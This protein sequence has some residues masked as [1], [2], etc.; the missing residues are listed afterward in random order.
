MKYN[1]VEIQQCNMCHSSLDMHRLLGLRMKGHQGFF[2]PRN[3]RGVNIYQCR[4]CGLIFCNPLPLPN[5]LQDHYGLPPDDYWEESWLAHDPAHFAGQIKVL[6]R[7]L[8]NAYGSK[9]LDVGAGT[10][11]TMAA[12]RRAGFQA[13]GFEPS[14]PFHKYAVEETGIDP[15]RI[16]PDNME[17]VV[18]G[19]AYFNFINF[20]SVLEHLSDPFEAINKSLSWL[21]PGGIIH[22]EVPNSRWLVSGLG[23]LFYKLTG[24]KYVANL[25]PLHPP[26]HLYEFSERSFKENA[27][28]LNYEIIHTD[29]YV[30]ETYLPRFLDPFLK[31]WMRLTGSEM[32][33]AVWIRKLS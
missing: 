13:Y 19:A 8:P 3:K 16:K 33:I 14:R 27:S 15:E 7:L 24:S 9:V 17:E 20:R 22:I 31:T 29:R 5:N 2:P 12:L 30:C 10:G 1:F 32:M 6:M 28:L 4:K 11:K 18:Y 25:S 23:N 26:F 21:S